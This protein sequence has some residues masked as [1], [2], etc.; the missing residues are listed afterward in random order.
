[1]KKISKSVVLFAG[2]MAVCALALP[3]MASA[4]SW[5]PVGSH[6]VLSSTNLAFQ[7]EGANAI[8]WSCASSTFTSDV[9]SAS[10]VTITATSFTNCMGILS[11]VN[12]TLT[13][14][15]RGF[16]WTATAT[17]PVLIHRVNVTMHIENTPGN[18]TACPIP[19]T[20]T[21]TGTLN[22][23]HFLN[24]GHE[25]NIT[26]PT[27]GT[28][29]TGHSAGVGSLPVTVSGTFRDQSQTLTLS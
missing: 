7:T 27:F 13:M 1:M 24:T 29:L 16:P 21:M 25:I 4:L 28:G 18:A 26:N 8:G 5:S 6:H 11:T 2:V 19:I 17:T 3:S 20:I 23:G 15:G 10:D 22:A 9:N 12:C 14:V